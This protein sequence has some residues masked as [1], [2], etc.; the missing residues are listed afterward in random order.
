MSGM[1]NGAPVGAVLVLGG[2]IAGMQAALDCANSG[3]KVYLVEQ[4]ASIGGNMARLDKTFPTNDCAM[5]MISPKLVETGRHLNIEII[6]NAD[7]KAVAGT[8]GRFQA[9]IKKR[10][11]YV[12]ENKCNGCGDCER[13]CPVTCRDAFN[14]DLG[15]RHAIHRLYPQAIPNVYAISK[16]GALPPCRG[17]CPAGVN[18]QGYVALIAK[19]KFLESLDVVRER[20][21]FAGICGRVCHH[22][23]ETQCNRAKVDEPIAVRHLKRFVADYEWSLIKTGQSIA[24]APSE[25]PVAEPQRYQERVAVVGGGPA[26]MTCANDLAKMGY[27]VTVFEAAEQLGGMMRQGIP[28]YRLPREVL[29][30]EIALI[31]GQG[32]DVRTNQALGRDFT[33]SDLRAQGYACTFVATGA[34]LP[35]RIPLEGSDAVGV[36]YGTSFLREVNV[37]QAPRLGKRIAVIGGGNVAIDAARCALRESPDSAVALYCLEARGEMPAHEWEIQEA[38]EEGIAIHPSWGPGRILVRNGAVRGLEL[39]RCL[40]V[41]DENRQFN[42]KFD[43]AETQQVTADTIILAVGQVCDLSFVDGHV[44][45]KHGLIAVDRIT[46]ETSMKGVFAGGDNVL[47]PASLVQ[48]VEQGHRAAESMHRF[49]R[50]L[51]LR[52]GREAVERSA[53]FAA[54][55]A[56]TPVVPARRIAIPTAS[57]EERKRSFLEMEHGYT[58]EMA[59]AEAQRCLNC[60]ICSQCNECVRVCKAHA[61]DHAM[62]DQDLT[63]EVGAVIVTNGY[64][65]FDP[66][67]KAEYGF[68]RY[69][70]VITSMQFERI[71]SASGPYQGHVRRPGDGKTPRK[72]AW[73]QCVGSRD[74]TLGRNYCSSVC[75]MYATKEAIIAKEHEKDLEP[76][77]FFIDLRAFGKGYEEFYNRAKSQYGVRYVRSQVSSLKENPENKNII[78]RYVGESEGRIR[79]VE[80][81]FDLVVLS[82]GMTARPDTAVLTQTLGISCNEYG[83]A[84]GSQALPLLSDREGIY[85]CGTVSGPKDIPETVM[86]SSAAAALCGQL[87]GRARGTRVRIKEYPAEREVAGEAPRIGVFICHCGTNIA[88]VV[89]VAAVAEYVKSIPGLTHAEHT[90]YACSQDTQERIKGIIQEKRLNR[91][92]VASCT[93]RTHEPLF[94]ETLREAGLNKYLFEMA[95]IREQCSWV[96]QG[97]SVRATE[98]A[99]A[100]VRGSIGKARNL[101]PLKFNRVGVTRCALVVGGGIAGLTAAHSLARQGFSVH[102]VEKSGTLGGQLRKVRRSLEGYDWQRHLENL[103]AQVQA[104]ESIT[105]HLNS[106]IAECN[107]FVGNFTTRLQGASNATINHGVTLVA[108]GA[109]EFQPDGFLYGGSPRVMTQQS[110]EEML[111]GGNGLRGSSGHAERPPESVVMIQCVGSRDEKRPYCSRVCCGAAVKNAL[112][113]KEKY[114]DTQVYVLYRDMRTYQYREEYYWQARDRGVVFIHFPDEEYPEVGQEGDRLRVSVRDTALGEP[115]TLPADWVVLSTAVVPDRASNGRLAELLKIPLNDH[116]FFMEAH[117]KLRP[118]DFANEGIFVCGLAHSPKYTEENISQALA[119]AGRAAC[120][121]SRNYLEVGGVISHV[122]QNKCAACLTCV[123]ECV[124]QAPFINAEGKAEI[125][126]AKCQGCGN[127]AA[128]C[129]AKAIQLQAFTDAQ[130]QALVRS[131]LNETAAEA[132]QMA[133]ARE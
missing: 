84:R 24:R 79:I 15:E 45:T 104:D 81:E 111:H 88:S 82:V 43:R 38:L 32:I 118:V 86:E 64:D 36:L 58:P 26:G 30:H 41:F 65:L 123:R 108:T 20:M 49:M 97:E 119:A 51:D 100:L 47:G 37:G 11:R 72:V 33:L 17:V 116:G 19:G 87:L 22:P 56:E 34:H 8:P 128:A 112:A 40:C 61:I 71:L 2:G 9:T 66:R 75:C 103:I 27:A 113:V 52:E 106:E 74:T 124:Y 80:E 4:Q 16:A 78:I 85:L 94:Q 109:A 131:L 90:L 91:V 6:A 89:D 98:K 29:D 5:C 130:E 50:G 114:P 23:C 83:F 12:D 13:A 62:R 102:L 120:I 68:G 133:L 122:N 18:A 95:D 77:I 53:E 101:E 14:G 55:P 25:A 117:I 46:L 121:L 35:K 127:C 73:I 3:F 126:E 48:A 54:P 10:A 115:L 39:V 93:P 31:T 69:P 1:N 59:M 28:A 125:E 21:P 110:L 76:T 99:K 105:V 96:H 44:Q 67:I 92:I 70:N 7:L 60:G 129:P 107:G 57:P 63:L 132:Q 42:P